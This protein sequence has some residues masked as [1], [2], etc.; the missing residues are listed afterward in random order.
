M[1]NLLWI[2]ERLL[3]RYFFPSKTQTLSK[4]LFKLY[5]KT[6][7]MAD[8]RSS[9]NQKYVSFAFDENNVAIHFNYF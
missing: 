9:K 5:R 1:L 7:K 2:R 8:R 4:S 6:L 3:K